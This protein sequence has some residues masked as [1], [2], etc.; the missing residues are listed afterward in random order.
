MKKSLLEVNNLKVF[1]KSKNGI[2]KAVN[3]VSFSLE[4][5]NILGI[6]GESGCGK[7]VTSLSIMGLLSDAGEIVDGQVIFK[8]KNLL[9]YND[10]EMRLPVLTI[11]KQLIE[12]IRA[13]QDITKE[14][15]K[16][17]ALD[18]LK[19]VGMPSPESRM[20][21]YPHQLSGGMKQRI[22]ISMALCYDSGSN[23]GFDKKTKK[24]L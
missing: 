12:T 17:I 9:N 3:G 10:E 4:N 8:G 7:S 23:I 24:R 18:I 15:A 13:H 22:M 2:V 5:G 20:N 6:V 16:L 11:S 21:E 14:K 1:F 19:K